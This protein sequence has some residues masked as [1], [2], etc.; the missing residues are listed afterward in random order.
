MGRERSG[1]VK[2]DN[3]IGNSVSDNDLLLTYNS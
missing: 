2:K 3:V 1:G